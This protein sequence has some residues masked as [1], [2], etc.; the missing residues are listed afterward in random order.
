[1]HSESDNL[2]EVQH[3]SYS[4]GPKRILNDFS[5]SVPQHSVTVLTGPNGAGK[6]TLI[7]IL[8]GLYPRYQGSILFQGHPLKYA[9]RGRMGFL[10]NGSFLRSDIPL[11]I[12]LSWINALVR[13]RDALELI[14][15]MECF[16]IAPLLD[17]R[18]GVLSHGERQRWSILLALMKRPEL[19][20]LDEPSD[21]LDPRFQQKLY[22]YIAE[23]VAEKQVSV[24]TV[25]QK[26]E[27]VPQP[28]RVIQL[29]PCKY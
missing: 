6:S 13:R 12:Q 10:F 16:E 1:M 17:K 19:L 20:I 5:I 25:T 22:Q 3:L 29:L 18:G 14:D 9:D 2:L 11:M 8:A 26:P 7:Y 28:Y 15:L 27:L 24:L 21:G 23:Q 4:S